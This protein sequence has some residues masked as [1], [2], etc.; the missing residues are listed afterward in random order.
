MLEKNFCHVFKSILVK[1]YDKS[2]L[3]DRLALNLIPHYLWTSHRNAIR[4]KAIRSDQ[5]KRESSG[6]LARKRA[7]IAVAT[8]RTQRFWL[9]RYLRAFS[10]LS[11][12]SGLQTVNKLPRAYFTTKV[13]LQN[14]LQGLSYYFDN[15]DVNTFFP[16]CYQVAAFS[17]G[18]NDRAKGISVLSV[19]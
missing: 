15:V 4:W 14:I 17:W 1:R 16:R 6:G 5:G 11:S 13:G 7:F 8:T 3:V 9:V 12:F 18:N 10:L 19:F 2:A